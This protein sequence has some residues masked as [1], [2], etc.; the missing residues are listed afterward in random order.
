MAEEKKDFW[1][2]VMPLVQ[3]LLDKRALEVTVHDV[4][5]LSGFADLFIVAISRSELNA[6]SLRECVCDMLD[7]MGLDYR[8]E[9]ESSIKWTLVDAGDVIVNILSRSGQEFYRLDSLWGD[10][11]TKRFT[12][13]ED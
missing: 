5:Q 4:S 9:G 12:D 8:M 13:E 7:K 3:A 6:R 2:P 1:T 10:A 11:P